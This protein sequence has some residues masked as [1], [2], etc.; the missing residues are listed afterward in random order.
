ME[1]VGAILVTHEHDDHVKGL[2]VLMKKYAV[3]TYMTEGTWRALPVTLGG[4]GT[5][6]NIKT[7]RT[8]QPFEVGPW[9]VRAFPTPHDANAPVG[10]VLE[11]DGFRLGIATD[12]GQM[13]DQMT[14]QLTGLDAVVLEFNHD[15]EMLA[16]SFYP[17]Y[18]KA[19]IAS[20]RRHLA[21]E[22]AGTLLRE[23]AH[24]GLRAVT[25][26]HLSENNNAPELA[27]SVAK[28]SLSGY[29]VRVEVAR[30]DGP[31]WVGDFVSSGMVG[32]APDDQLSFPLG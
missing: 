26:A 8:M 19:R 12:I 20:P 3:P 4:N 30:Q 13:T 14:D 16:R 31:V 21:N 7:F 25:L 1:K 6:P 24:P 27:R 18:V 23:I 15:P 17:E 32:S 10:F 5:R 22:E 2:P 11:A 29:D 28:R 9:A